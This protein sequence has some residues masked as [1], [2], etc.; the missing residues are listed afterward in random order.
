MLSNDFNIIELKIPLF[1]ASMVFPFAFI[2]I[3][4]ILLIRLGWPGI[5]GIMVPVLIFPIQNY[6]PGQDRDRGR[7]EGIEETRRP[8]NDRD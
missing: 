2:G 7:I 8:G 4:I 1:F 5:I 3:S 6:W